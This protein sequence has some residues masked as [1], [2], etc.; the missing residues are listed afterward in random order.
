MIIVHNY[1]SNLG[2]KIV[3]DKNAS[4]KLNEWNYKKLSLSST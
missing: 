4:G 1:G 3:F 2:K